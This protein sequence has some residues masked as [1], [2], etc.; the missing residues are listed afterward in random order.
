MML[1]SIAIIVLGIVGSA[2]FSGTETAFTSLLRRKE[3][4]WHLPKNI[5]RWL[6][7]P[8]ELLSVTLIGT[9]VFV[10]LASSV[11]AALFVER[12]GGAGEYYSLIVISLS[13]LIFGEV[14][15]KSMALD[16]SEPFA[17]AVAAPLGIAGVLLKPFSKITNG[18]SGAVV[19]SIHFVLKSPKPPTYKDFE[20]VS[21]KGKLNIGE[22]REA[23]IHLF[24]EVS[25]TKAFDIMTPRSE[26]PTLRVSDDR[27]RAMARFEATGQSELPVEDDEGR[28]IGILAVSKAKSIEGKGIGAAVEKP[29]YVPENAP[30]LGLFSDMYESGAN[31]ALVI[32]EHGN[33]TGGITREALARF[34]IGEQGSGMIP[35][36]PFEDIVL[37]GSTDIHEFERIIGEEIPRGPF[38]SLGGFI[39]EIAREIPPEGARLVW[40]RW[41]FTILERSDKAVERVRV[42][43]I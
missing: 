31:S 21:T 30:I 19:K 9:N 5:T 35:K 6:E 23:M 8:D 38:K 18:L 22:S 10:I 28:I 24:F 15:P 27:D 12:F 1:L 2:F 29:F 36:R 33:T 39:E 37:L 20:M 25:A 13:I 43:L 14:L 26:M 32:D 40:K 17:K 4:L 41:A 3:S 16:R 11:S 7:R 34:L 42:R